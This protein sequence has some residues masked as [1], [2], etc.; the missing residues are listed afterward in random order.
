MIIDSS[1]DQEDQLK[2]WKEKN[3]LAKSIEIVSSRWEDISTLAKEHRDNVAKVLTIVSDHHES[4]QSINHV[5]A[6]GEK[7]LN[8][9]PPS[10]FDVEMMRTHLKRT[11]VR[12][13]LA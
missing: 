4:L 12:V 3:K 9:P 1:K 13:F 8:S 11:R 6:Q 7:T 2:S 10:V 5:I